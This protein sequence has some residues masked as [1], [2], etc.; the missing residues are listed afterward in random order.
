MPVTAEAKFLLRV[1]STIAVTAIAAHSL[2]ILGDGVPTLASPYPAPLTLLAFLGVP[3]IIAAAVVGCLFYLASKRIEAEVPRL[4]GGAALGLS[5]AVLASLV[6]F[7]LGWSYGV[8]YQGLRFV[9]LS[10]L[11]SG[12]AV[13]ALCVLLA[14]NRRQPTV[15]TALG[16]YILLFGWLGSYA[17]PYL[18]EGP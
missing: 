8:R 11:I 3:V 9:A 7:V 10:V 2:G 15:S 17:M 6:N 14:V 5:V 18:G 4:G 12:C 13:A 16:F 1:V